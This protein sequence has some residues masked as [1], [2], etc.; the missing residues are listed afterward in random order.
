MCLLAFLPGNATDAA[1]IAADWNT[2]TDGTI[3]GITFTT[4]GFASNFLAISP[5]QSFTGSSYNAGMLSDV[6]ALNYGASNDWTATFATPLLDLYIYARVWRGSFTTGPDLATNYVFSMPFTIL[7]GMTG[8]NVS[9]NTLT[10]ADGTF[11][12]GII[13]VA[14]PVSS[15]SIASDGIN[16]SGQTLT[17]ATTVPEP[18][19]AGLALAGGLGLAANSRR[20]R[21]TRH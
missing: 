12:S 20:S 19:S 8:A 13:R 16:T 15:F 1:I 9:G 5:N 7:S 3:N 2:P 10:L 18:T 14:G 21:R 11:Y 4:F 6:D 17:F